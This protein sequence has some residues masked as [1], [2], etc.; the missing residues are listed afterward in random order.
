MRIR[1]LFYLPPPGDAV[2]GDLP[3][4]R[5]A[6]CNY[7]APPL[8]SKVLLLS[9]MLAD[10]AFRVITRWG[11]AVSSLAPASPHYIS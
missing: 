11:S 10:F 1:V 6:L 7:N 5:H 2:R 3:E 4:F 8:L 9:S